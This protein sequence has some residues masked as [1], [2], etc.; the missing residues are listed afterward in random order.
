VADG[1]QEGVYPTEFLNSLNMAGVPPHKL[2]LQV[3]SPIILL[4]NMTGGLANGTRLIVSKLMDR[5]IE[6]KVA[7]GPA[8]GKY[9]LIPRLKITPSDV[10]GM[11]FTLVRLQFPVRAAYAMTINK[12]QGQTLAKVG[13]YLPK[14]C[15]LTWSAI[16]GILSGGRARGC[17]GV[18]CEWLEGCITSPSSGSVH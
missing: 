13:V 18:G 6:A 5:V 17:E 15:V 1:E 4:R 7:T 9:V 12:S 16:C 14:P 10:E 2:R 8:A 11:P 3:G